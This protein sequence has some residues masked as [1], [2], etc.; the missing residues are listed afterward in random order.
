MNIR[1]NQHNRSSNPQQQ[2]EDVYKRN[3]QASKKQTNGEVPL[4]TFLAGS[5]QHAY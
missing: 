3:A 4:D 5:F 2:Q 1:K